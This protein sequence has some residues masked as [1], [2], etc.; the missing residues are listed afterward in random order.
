VGKG[1]DWGRGKGSAERTACE[2]YS[3]VL[4]ERPE[5]SEIGFTV[6][7]SIPARISRIGSSS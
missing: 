4:R 6:P 2:G 1:L 5:T 7:R 3:D